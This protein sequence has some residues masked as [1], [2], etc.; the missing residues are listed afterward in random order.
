MTATE[1]FT[2]YD[3]QA[4]D[5]LDR[6]RLYLTVKFKSNDCPPWEEDHCI[7]GDEYTVTLR[8]H[9]GRPESISFSFWNSQH[10]MQEG[11]SP[12]AYNVLACISSDIY[13]PE[14]FEEFCA[15]YGYDADSRKAEKTF[16]RA[17]R[18]ARRLRA[19]FHEDE[20]EQ[21]SEIR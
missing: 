10:D 8:R 13:T 5:F 7:H 19:F 1:T 3:A 20:R 14:T 6:N 9:T 18:L 11:K 16:K 12:T 21:L 2:S 17:D 4:K 15:E